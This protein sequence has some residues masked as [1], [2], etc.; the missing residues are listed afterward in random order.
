MKKISD[1]GFTV[2][3]V[4]IASLVFTTLLLLSMEGITRI[5]KVYVKNSSITKANE[6]SKSFI[7]DIAQQIKYGVE[8]KFTSGNPS[9]LCVSD[10]GYKIELNKTQEEDLGPIP[11]NPIVKIQDPGCT[12]YA[13]ASNYTGASY[14][15]VNISPVNIRILS[16]NIIKNTVGTTPV[17]TI[18][19]RVALGAKDLLRDSANKILADDPTANYS[20]AVCRGGIAGS[21]FCSVISI[22]TSITRRMR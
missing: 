14:N 16:F 15:P 5:A 10:S 13:N 7:G 3:E 22:S 21:E 12:L 17:W 6:F 20:E 11:I 8:P 19:M 4:L 2:I 1:K 9:F 18:D